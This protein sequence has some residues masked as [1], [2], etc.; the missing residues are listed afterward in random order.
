MKL[1]VMTKNVQSNQHQKML[2]ILLIL[3]LSVMLSG[4]AYAVLTLPSQAPGLSVWA[5][6]NLDN[7]GV[8]NPVTAVL[9]N[10]RGYDTLLEMGVLLLALIG[11]WSLSDSLNKKRERRHSLLDAVHFWS[12]SKKPERRHALPGPVLDILARLL[13]PLLILV[14]GYLLWVGAHAPGGAF[15][16]G[17]VLGAAGVL[18]LLSDVHYESRFSGLSLRI[19]LIM[20]L[21]M[22]VTVG[23]LLILIG[24]QLLEYPPAFAGSLILI[25]EAAATLSIGFTL[26]ALFLGERPT[27]QFTNESTRSTTASKTPSSKTPQSK[28]REQQ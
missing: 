3:I 19:A 18:L 16:A 1:K 14:A 13:V 21:G 17:S 10:Y 5:M 25:I 23:L 24:R 4:L 26:A 15:Q 9:L 8:S 28:T 12:G 27:T 11:V 6:A 22:F 20:G 7:S 2:K